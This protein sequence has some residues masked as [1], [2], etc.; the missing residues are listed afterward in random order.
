MKALALIF[1]A[2]VT[3]LPKPIPPPTWHLARG[4]HLNPHGCIVSANQPVVPPPA[5]AT[6]SPA[7]AIASYTRALVQTKESQ[8]SADAQYRLPL[9]IA[10]Y[11][12][13]RIHEA[14]TQ[15]RT[16]IAHGTSPRNPPSKAD[17]ATLLALQGRF[18]DALMQY[19]LS[20]PPFNQVSF[21]DSGAAYNLQRGLNAAANNNIG[22]A[23]RFLGYALECAAGNFQVPH[24]ALAAIAAQNRDFLTARHEWLATLEAWDPSTMPGVTPAQYD[25]IWLLLHYD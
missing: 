3:T 19:A 10:L 7:T 17:S 15:W 1:L 16:L 25:A 21:G 2:A 18:Q 22:A 6:A 24:L 20:P 4:Y 12:A 13:G 14:K 9:S 11:R 8:S 23:R 5:Q